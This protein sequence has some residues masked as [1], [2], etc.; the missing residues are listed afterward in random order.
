M[1]L[2]P[3]ER[4]RAWPHENQK[5][6][7][8]AAPSLREAPKGPETHARFHSLP[9][10]G[11]TTLSSHRYPSRQVPGHSRRYLQGGL[12]FLLLMLLPV[13]EHFRLPRGVPELQP[14]PLRSQPTRLTL[15]RSISVLHAPQ[16]RALWRWPHRG[17]VQGRWPDRAD[18]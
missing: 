7:R 12:E 15:Y 17:F 9:V 5:I 14:L 13:R 3:P 16:R 2:R 11:S 10:E 18:E 4:T 6:V 8:R 1:S